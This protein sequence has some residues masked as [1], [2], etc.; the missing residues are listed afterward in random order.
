[1]E[2]ICLTS[3]L[4]EQVRRSDRNPGGAFKS[5]EG[6]LWNNVTRV[7]SHLQATL[8]NLQHPRSLLPQERRY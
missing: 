1:M 4:T 6:A 5:K 8:R 2:L 7:H 3:L